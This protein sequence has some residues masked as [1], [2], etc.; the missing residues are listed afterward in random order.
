MLWFIHRESGADLTYSEYSPTRYSSVHY[1]ESLYS[2]FRTALQRERAL[3]TE[4]V[5]FR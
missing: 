3:T 5:K 4:A 1:I 2:S